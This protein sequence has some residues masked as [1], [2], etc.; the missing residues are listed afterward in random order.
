M[1]RLCEN[2]TLLTTKYIDEESTFDELMRLHWSENDWGGE[3]ALYATRKAFGD[4]VFAAIDPNVWA[5]AEDDA[6]NE[7]I[8]HWR[9]R[10]MW[11]YNGVR[12]RDFYGT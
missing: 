11:R 12:Q 9:R 6:K 2:G 5:M 3:F 10:D 1:D 7:A 4:A 8:D